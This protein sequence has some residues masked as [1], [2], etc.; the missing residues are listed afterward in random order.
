MYATLY[1]SDVDRF[2]SAAKYE[3]ATHN[4]DSLWLHVSEMMNAQ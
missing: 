4:G 3:N 2:T 1:D